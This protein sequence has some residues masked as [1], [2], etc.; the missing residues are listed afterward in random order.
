[1]AGPMLLMAASTRG[2][3]ERA[4]LLG[5][6]KMGNDRTDAAHDCIEECG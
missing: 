2:M 1:M 6:S 4:P 5:P 3:A